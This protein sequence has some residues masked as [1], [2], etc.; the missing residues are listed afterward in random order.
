YAGGNATGGGLT[1]I[2][3]E[4]VRRMDDL[5][6]VHD[7]SHLSQQALDELL[8]M[9]DAT[10]IATHSNAR[11]LM[12]EG[13]RH[14]SDEAIREITRRG[15]VVGLNLYSAFLAPGLGEAGRATVDD[16]AGHIEHICEVAGTRRQVGLGS[17]MDGGFA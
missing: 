2:G 15:G 7:V 14:L 5:G 12:G 8:E 10:V 4:L 16:C 11:A 3:R 9:T 6:I 1:D 17:D 13:E